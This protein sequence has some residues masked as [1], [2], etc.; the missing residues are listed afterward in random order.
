MI[1]YTVSALK[2]HSMAQ[3]RTTQSFMSSRC[4]VRVCITHLA[5]VRGYYSPALP[6]VHDALLKDLLHFSCL[7]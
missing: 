1:D 6:K 2:H 5:M 4:T 3:G 7:S